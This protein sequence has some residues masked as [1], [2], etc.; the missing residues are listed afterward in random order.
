MIETQPDHGTVPVLF[1][2]CFLK[3]TP[4]LEGGQRVLYCEPSNEATDMEGE[5]VIDRFREGGTL[6]VFDWPSCRGKYTGLGEKGTA[7]APENPQT[8]GER[9]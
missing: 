9:V 2:T 4:K 5:R 1:E 6:V 8:K 3:A 7:T